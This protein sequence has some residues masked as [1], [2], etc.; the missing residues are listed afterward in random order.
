MTKPQQQQR[1][2]N[3][4]EEE[5][6]Y[7]VEVG[8]EEESYGYEF[9]CKSLNPRRAYRKFHGAEK[10]EGRYSGVDVNQSLVRGI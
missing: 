8:Q 5:Q 7:K 6:K 4:L 10:M 3:F 2:S 9:L 1:H